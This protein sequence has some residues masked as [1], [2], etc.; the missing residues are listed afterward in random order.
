MMKVTV[1]TDDGQMICGA[2][3]VALL[4]TRGY[5]LRDRAFAV[6]TGSQ[7]TITC[8]GCGRESYNVNDVEHKYC[9]HCHVYHEE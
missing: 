1:W 6:G 4:S 8:L 7:T 5:V 3:G 2:G 9:G